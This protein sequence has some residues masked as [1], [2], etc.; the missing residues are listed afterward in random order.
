MIRKLLLLLAAVVVVFA[1]VA[2]M[3]PADFRVSRSASIAAPPAAVFAQINDLHNWEKWSPWAKRDPQMKQTYSG[4]PA[5]EG[6][7]YHWAGN[8]EVG[9]GRMTIVESKADKLV[10]LKLEFLKPLAAT[11]EAEFVFEPQGNQ[12]A[13]S[14]T[15][16]GDKNLFAKAMHMVI[17][18][19]KMIGKDFEQGLASLKDLSESAAAK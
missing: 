16:T 1:V 10:R 9:E 6:A 14:W 15:M 18:I 13:V 7:S 11:N 4:A 19:D 5:G 3:Q 8:A 17:N 12:T 2:A